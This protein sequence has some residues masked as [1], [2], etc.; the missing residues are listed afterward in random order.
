M[1]PFSAPSEFSS[2]VLEHRY[3]IYC[4]ST[5]LE[6]LANKQTNIHGIINGTLYNKGHRDTS[7]GCA[8]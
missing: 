2:V 1:K 5:Q 7:L 3:Y 4:W 6:P 8:V